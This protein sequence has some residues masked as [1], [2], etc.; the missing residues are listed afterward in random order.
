LIFALV[1]CGAAPT[2]PAG[3]GNLFPNSDHSSPYYVGRALPKL[4]TPQWVGEEGVE[5]VI[6][7]A[8]DDMRGPEKWENYLRPI[9]ERLKQIDGRAPVSI[10]TCQID[11]QEPH[12]QTWL[13]EG[14]SLEI[15]T[16]DH[17]C[18]ILKDG[19]F[20]K[21]KGTFDRCVDLLNS[22]PGNRP[23]A[24]R[25]PC[26]D[27]LN[28]PSPRFY[29]EIFNKTTPAGNFLELDSSV[30]NL[31]T[32]ADPELPR[33]RV[34]DAEGRERFEKYVPR[35][36]EFVNTIENYPYP[37]VIGRLCWQFPCVV[38]SDW[39]AQFLQKPF[40][41]QTVEDM[42]AAIDCTVAKQGVFNLVF[43]PHGWIRNDQVVELIDH[44]QKK[45]G[46]KV[47][48]L[49]FHEARERLN[50][51]FLG[52]HSLRDDK[53]QFNGVS[54][55]DVNNDGYLDA[56][57]SNEHARSTRLW[58]TSSRRMFSTDFPVPL[59]EPGADGKLQETQVRFGVVDERGSTG[60]FVQHGKWQ[61]LWRYAH[62]SWQ[63]IGAR[64]SALRSSALRS[65]LLGEPESK[66]RDRGNLR[67]VDF[68]CDGICELLVGNRQA[69]EIYAIEADL[70][71]A[72]G[73]RELAPPVWRKLN[74]TLPSVTRAFGA[75]GGDAGLRLV[76]IN[77][78]GFDD[79]VFSDA[80]RY[81]I[82]L[83][84]SLEKG[85]TKEVIAGKRGETDPS[86]ELPPIVRADGTNNGFFVHSRH[87][88][89]QNEDTARMK[90]L[91]DRRSFDELLKDVQPGPK[92]PEAS[93]KS[94]SVRPG[95]K[96]ELVA[97]EPLV[98]DPVGF[99]WGADGKLWVVEMA[100]YPLG[101]DGQGK[102]GGRVRYLEDTDG[103]GRYDR[104]TLFLDGL[105]YPNGVAPWRKGALVS[106]APEIFYAEDT[107]GDGKADKREVLYRGFGEGNQQHR[108]NGFTYGLDNW[109]YGANG[110]SGGK[111]KSLVNGEEVNIGG[112]DFR[113]DP[114]IGKIDPQ[115][116][117]AQFGR[118]R[119]D[120]GNWFGSN[121]SNPLFH[122][123]LADQYLRRNEHLAAPDGRVM[124][125]IAPGA[126]PVYPTSRTL[127]R[128][129]DFNK[130]N[131][132]TSACSAILYRDELFGP[133]YFGNSFVCEPVHNLVHREIVS[134]KG[135]TFTS[136]RADDEQQSEFLAS[137]DNW[138]RPTMVKTG[139]DGALWIADMYRQV[140]EHPQWI[141][142]DWQ[143]RLDLRAGHDR[144]RI[145][146]IVPENKP[147]RAIPRLADKS[148]AALV[149]ALDSPSGWQR[150][151][152]QQL[153]VER[154]DSSA[155]SAL[156][157]MVRQARRPLARL[158]A[159]CTL[160][161]LK[162]LDEPTLLAAIDDEHP[163][164][165]R[166]AAR[167]SEEFLDESPQLLA[168]MSKLVNDDD[169]QLRLQVAYSL[170]A[171]TR[172]Q[173][174]EALARLL[175][176]RGDDRYLAA[177][178]L[179]SVR[180]AQL[181]AVLA[182]VLGNGSAERHGE[183]IATLLNLA[184]A[185]RSEAALAQALAVIAEPKEN[186]Y[187]PWQLNSL[188]GL[189]DAL[190][191]RQMSLSKLQKKASG[192]LAQSLDKLRDAFAYARQVAAD[193]RAPD[194]DRV[195]AVALLGRGMDRRQE[196]LDALASLL[197]PQ[198]SAAVQIAV[199]DALGK[200]DDKNIPQIVLAG[201]KSYGPALRTRAL[202]ALASRASGQ[203]ALLAALE[204]KQLLAADIDA[205]RRQQL[206]ARLKG[207][208]RERAETLLTSGA[209]SNRQRVIEQYQAA[210]T[211]TGDQTRGAAVFKKT[212]SACHRLGDVGHAIGPDLT[213]LTDR[214]P[215]SMLV[216]MLDPNRAVEAKFVSYTAVTGDGRT[217]TG[218]LAGET[219][220]SVTLVGQENKQ[221]LILRSD[222][223]ALESSGKSLMPEGMEKD[224]P[225]QAVADVIAFLNAQGPPRKAF[226]GNNPEVVRP[227]VDG[228]IRL[229][230]TMCEIY[231]KTLVFEETYRNLGYW[232]SENDRAVWEFEIERPGKYNV[233]L[234]Y[235]CDKEAG[236]HV[237]V[238]VDSA[239]L[240]GEV[241]GSGGWDNYRRM[242]LGDVELAAGRHKLFVHSQGTIKQ[243]LMDLREIRLTPYEKSP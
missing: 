184:A 186:Q 14:L 223:E 62:P 127:A 238:D 82:H 21:A 111:I 120:W 61:G 199:L 174:S 221:Q 203:Q 215:R 135:S 141:P 227:Y 46:K 55:L 216:A 241:K 204:N 59:V 97:A 211:M 194:S 233:S 210:V 183:L 103:D 104:S 200:L 65:D 106:C 27:S 136:R 234:D 8:I 145:Y 208:D 28:T 133:E 5:A 123:V 2:L 18:P 182:E 230:A 202:D 74:I 19:D 222:L 93:L 124:V 164:V 83:F 68:D 69:T 160:D 128:F 206:L 78:D 217:F 89:W 180:D 118:H 125:S 98:M 121:N 134:P 171:S 32:S 179:S 63:Q 144:G 64:T 101:I 205:A 229:L 71:N 150:D 26:C 148:S 196:D 226:A 108:A 44:A 159:L 156:K 218:M 209:D 88:W 38:P 16:Y 240:V 170:G 130:A 10:M 158:H 195:L 220:N 142:P 33:E 191:R 30:F 126:S 77:E 57:I 80:E 137:S 198:T 48:F 53:G 50:K 181:P 151:M 40:N 163:G 176:A 73:L 96:V 47:K 75:A 31:F 66:Q 193:P 90:N 172:P 129:N 201:W 7:L 52:G 34:L 236:N 166:H 6:V 242:K 232:H 1:I 49:T 173:A 154:Q 54:V 152:A 35:E 161:G 95:F 15:H 70:R 100:D 86:Q 56:V 175:L 224:L 162:S 115:A 79:V 112:R 43:H 72:K 113:I 29:A 67:F 167:L 85:W 4:T 225:P 81:S 190:D 185:S 109:F 214:S 102:H 237:A 42:K 13:K 139:P 189:L 107:D 51:N 140:I 119:D 219:G 146:R 92:S 192:T 153:L 20:A 207:R 58:G 122:Y 39:E 116:G 3:V 36:R 25:V 155:A 84:E 87:L 114:A 157:Q 132:F 239:Q 231:G 165:R 138:F 37:Y 60:F 22:V 45:H 188:A 177:A 212:C 99:A 197:A 105:G 9:L 147:P 110:D 131:R 187:A 213:A 178:A 11:P 17:P 169:P 228:S 23:I 168:A 143:K 243:A 235:A 41:P 149:A 91:V 24:F 117:Q 12:L 76:D 94:M